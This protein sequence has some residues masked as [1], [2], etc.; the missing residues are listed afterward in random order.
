M[1]HCREEISSAIVLPGCLCTAS[2]FSARMG[3]RVCHTG[4]SRGQFHFCVHFYNQNWKLCF[5]SSEFDLLVSVFNL[6]LC[7]IYDSSLFF[8]LGSSWS[9]AAWSYLCSQPFQLI[10][11]SPLTVCS[12]WYE[13]R[14]KKKELYYFFSQFVFA[15][16]SDQDQD[17]GSRTQSPHNESLPHSERG[18][19]RMSENLKP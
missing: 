1:V 17:Q 3:S 18:P 6:H 13:T 11:T 16:V 14:L 4:K 10:R 7:C 12:F 2:S 5:G 8:C 19:K 15:F 9:S